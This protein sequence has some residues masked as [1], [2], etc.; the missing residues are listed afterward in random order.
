MERIR[1]T[2][3]ETKSILSDVVKDLI[4]RGEYLR[5]IEAN[6][7]FLSDDVEEMAERSKQLER[8]RECSL[9]CVVSLGS[10]FCFLFF[11]FVSYVIF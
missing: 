1:N 10:I 5:R 11:F 7:R 8:Q 9:C 3:S 4:T 6:T 2:L